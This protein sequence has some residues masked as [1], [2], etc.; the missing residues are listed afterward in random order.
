LGWLAF[1][2]LGERPQRE[3]GR[4]GANGRGSEGERERMG[5]GAR[6]R[7]SEWAR[8][9]IERHCDIPVPTG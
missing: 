9:L 6:E 7:R 4:E 1:G 8:A 5:E 3:P 2:K